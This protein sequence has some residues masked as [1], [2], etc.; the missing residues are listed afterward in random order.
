MHE[1]PSINKPSIRFTEKELPGIKDWDI[2]KKY[3]LQIE[4]TLKSKGE[5]IWDEGGI[6]GRL[7]IDAVKA[8]GDK[9]QEDK[10]KKLKAKYQ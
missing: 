9:D 3:T 7:Q 4:V 2:N 10:V 5:D 6:G 1:T 8:V